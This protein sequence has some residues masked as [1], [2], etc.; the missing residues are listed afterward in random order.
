MLERFL[1][2]EA[3]T[4][5]S[6]KKTINYLYENYFIVENDTED[7][8]LHKKCLERIPPSAI[9]N[10]YV[11][12]SENCNFNCKYCFIS[13][14][15]QK[16]F[17]S[18]MMSNETAKMAV[19]LLQRTY[20][21][22]KEKYDKTITFYGGEPLLN[23]GVIQFF[24]EEI[25]QVKLS[26]NYWPSNVR[27]AIITNGSLITNEILNILKQYNIALSIS[28]D[29]DKIAQSKRVYKNNKDSFVAV[30]D[31]IELCRKR[32]HPFGLS[33]T[34]SE[35][36]IENREYVINE[37]KRMEPV[38]VAFN[39]LIPNR[40]V[41]PPSSYYERAT[42]F[43]I[44]AFQ[45][46]REVGIYEDRIMRKVHSFETG[47]LFLYDC[48]ASGGNQFVI[49]PTGEIGICH[50]YLNDNKFFTSNVSD[51]GFDFRKNDNFLYWRNRTPLRMEQCANCECIGIC[52]GGCPYAADYMYGSIYEVCEPYCIHAKKI[53]HWMIVDLYNHINQ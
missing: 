29:I 52:G 19:A 27:Y 33:I 38:T 30:R 42:D 51:T 22:Q 10:V 44:E 18:K 24:M 9:S 45:E 23:I 39:L 28:Y 14:I 25:N 41:T 20:E 32:N 37:I 26:G 15:V 6:D 50:G 17:P 31:N 40:F 43:M 48:C 13:D 53:L 4:S 36:T 5:E 1:N 47:N 21:R 2:G 7:V 16:D 12:V 34:I 49:N 46:L 3:P 35:E 11:V 8:L